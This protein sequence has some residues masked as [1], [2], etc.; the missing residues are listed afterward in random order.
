MSLGTI[1]LS[2]VVGAHGETPNRTEAAVVKLQKRLQV[3]ILWRRV[4]GCSRI[5]G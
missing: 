4:D 2:A 3:K 5:K 1:V